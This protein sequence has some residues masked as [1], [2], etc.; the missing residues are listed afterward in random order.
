MTTIF[1][2]I[3]ARE[4]PADI[5]Y[6]DDIVL[7]FLDI[8][9]VNKGHILVI[10]K[11]PT[12]DALSTDPATLAH[13]L[14]VGQKIGQR[15]IQHLPCDGINI[16][17]NNGAAAGQEVFHTHLHVIP[18]HVNDGSFSHAKHVTYENGEATRLAA[19]LTDCF[20]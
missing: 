4:V 15:L 10:P 11:T 17:F 14:L 3:I 1:S 16:G 8:N 12:P 13:I 5:V 6:E 7:A 20:M 19:R 18:R 2:K 9:P